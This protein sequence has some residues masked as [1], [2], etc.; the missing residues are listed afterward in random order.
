MAERKEELWMSVQDRDRLKVLHAVR[1]RHVTQVQAARELGVSNRWVRALLQRMKQE[2]DGWVVHRK[3]PLTLKRRAVE[4]FSEQKRAKQWHDY[5]PTLA[6]E[7]LARDY[8]LVVSKETLRQWLIGAGLWKAHRAR[9]KRVHSWRARRARRARYGELVQWDT[10]EHDWLEGRG[11]ELYLIA[12][13]DDATSRLTAGFVRHD[14]TEENL[15]QLGHYIEHHG[16]PLSVYTD[17]ASLF[18]TPEKRKRDEPG[19]DKDP[20]EMPPTQI[21]R[22]LGELGIS[23]VAAHSPQAKGRVERNFETAQDRLVKG[24]GWRG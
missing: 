14:S 4:V 20:V 3:L 21:A 10:S 23:W 5:G 6:A 2:G 22:A 9:V 24:C 13:I 7:E 11:E 17:K 15:R 16:R 12:M 8:H 18:R 19:V 1:R